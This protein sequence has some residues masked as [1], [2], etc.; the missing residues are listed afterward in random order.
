MDY[1]ANV[2]GILW[3]CRKVLPQIRARVPDVRL[4]IVGSR[5]AAEVQKL[6]NGHSIIVTGFVKDIRPWYA[7]A[8]ICIVPLRI[9]RGIQNKVLEAMAMGKPVVST[10]QA[11]QGL[12]TTTFLFRA[13]SPGAFS[14]AVTNLIQSPG[15]AEVFGRQARKEV[16]KAYAW[17]IH[18]G[19]MAELLTKG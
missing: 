14:G 11:L 9:A 10:S 3:F 6:D 4:Y 13:D 7:R 12:A 15:K 8:D 16:E 17:P 19:H 5:P 18:M 2:D 1:H